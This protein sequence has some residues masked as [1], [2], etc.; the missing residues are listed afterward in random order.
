MAAQN[1]GGSLVTF[2][3]DNNPETS[4]VIV[5]LGG[6]F[7]CPCGTD[8]AV[9]GAYLAAHW[10]EKM[11]TRC[12]R[13]DQEFSL[14]NGRCRIMHPEVWKQAAKDQHVTVSQSTPAEGRS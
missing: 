10:A 1:G 13:C 2:G 9:D 12:P 4:Q 8:I 6:Q 14:R 3:E 5:R 7:R 11:T